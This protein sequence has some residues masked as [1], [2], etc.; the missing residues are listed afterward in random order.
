MIFCVLGIDAPYKIV[1]KVSGEP[2]LTWY[3]DGVPIKEDNRVKTVKVS[4]EHF[5]LTFQKTMAE[6]NGNWAV[7]ARNP[8]GEM[9]QFFA[10]AALQFPKFDEKLKDQEA[11]EGKQVSLRSNTF[12]T[13]ILKNFGSNDAMSVFSLSRGIL[14]KYLHFEECF[15][16]SNVFE[17]E[18]TVFSITMNH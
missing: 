16:R 18:R 8:H 10:F 11:N 14:M 13:K 2:E 4:P 12:L 17:G 6:D 5:E 15:L 1:A 3:K 7:I 9:S